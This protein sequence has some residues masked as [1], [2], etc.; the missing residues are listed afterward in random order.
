MFPLFQLILYFTAA[1]GKP[2]A[3][4][5]T[6]AYTSNEACTTDIATSSLMQPARQ[7]A[8]TEATGDKPKQD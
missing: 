1:R 3:D 6:A 5:A 7:H 4:H 8:A 2:V